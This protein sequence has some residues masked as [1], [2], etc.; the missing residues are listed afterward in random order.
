MVNHDVEQSLRIAGQVV[1]LRGGRV[2]LDQPT[3]RL[4]AREVLSEVRP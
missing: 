4:Y 2:V 1:V 3:H